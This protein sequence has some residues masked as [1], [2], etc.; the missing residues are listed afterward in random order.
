MDNLKFGKKLQI[1][2]GKVDNFEEKRWKS[3]EKLKLG[4][5]ANLEKCGNLEKFG[6]LEKQME[7]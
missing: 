7:V 3:G 6:N 5:I 2:V 4:K 1:W